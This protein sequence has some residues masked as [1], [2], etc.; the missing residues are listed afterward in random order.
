MENTYTL[1]EQET[2]IR[3]DRKNPDAEIYTFESY[4]KRRLKQLAHDYPDQ[5]KLVTEGDGSVEYN[6]PKGLVTIRKPRSLSEKTRSKL[7]DNMAKARQK[8]RPEE[9]KAK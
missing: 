6:I 3:W 8:K 5:V 7:A 1:E 2:I 4:L 9:G